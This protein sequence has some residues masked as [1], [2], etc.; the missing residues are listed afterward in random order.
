MAY[1]QRLNFITQSS[2]ILWKYCFE[3]PLRMCWF[4]KRHEMYKKPVMFSFFSPQ[5]AVREEG[6][7]FE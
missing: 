4:K 1:A 2:C 5:F 3:F 7:I 6:N